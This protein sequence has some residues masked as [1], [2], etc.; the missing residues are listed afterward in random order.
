MAKRFRFRL[1]QV[2]SLRRQVEEVRVRELAQAKGYLLRVEEALKAHAEEESRFLETYGQFERVGAFDSDQAMAYCEFKDWLLRR[3]KEYRRREKEWA[4]EVEK[5]RQAAVKASRDRRLLERLKEKKQTEHLREEAGEEQKFLDEV[6][7]IAF[8]R[9][10]RAQ[11]ALPAEG[12]K[13]QLNNL[14]R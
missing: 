11:R 6:S 7:S 3:E 2:L 12:A 14:R 13:A 1:E 4:E 9:R 8:V 5:R 10:D